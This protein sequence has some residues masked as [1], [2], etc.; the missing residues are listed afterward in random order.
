MQIKWVFRAIVLLNRLLKKENIKFIYNINH[1]HNVCLNK[2]RLQKHIKNEIA[3][4][5]ILGLPVTKIHQ[6]IV[7][8]FDYKNITKLHILTKS[9]L[10]YIRTTIEKLIRYDD[11]DFRN[12]KAYL[13]HG[14]NSSI[15]KFYL[16]K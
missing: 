1:E 14:L 5:I 12:S 10:R 7:S 6:N 11:N 3:Q 9:Y 16:F 15:I 8:S 2:I 13:E 4:Q